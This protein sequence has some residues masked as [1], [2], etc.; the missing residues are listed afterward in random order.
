MLFIL[1]L[2]KQNKEQSKISELEFDWAFGYT[3]VKQGTQLP[4]EMANIA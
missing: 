4:R 1:N 3:G 2:L